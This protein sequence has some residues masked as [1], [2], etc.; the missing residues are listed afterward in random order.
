MQ[1][2]HSNW[3]VSL[4]AITILSGLRSRF[5]LTPTRL[6]TEQLHISSKTIVYYVLPSILAMLILVVWPIPNNLLVAPRRHCSC[7]PAS[8]YGEQPGPCVAVSPWTC[9]CSSFRNRRIRVW[10]WLCRDILC[11]RIACSCYK[12]PRSWGRPFGS[13]ACA[14]QSDGSLPKSS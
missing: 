2:L 10:S 11:V 6:L 8:L 14:S 4:V 12:R 1:Y 13:C 7:S 3:C 9:M 5:L